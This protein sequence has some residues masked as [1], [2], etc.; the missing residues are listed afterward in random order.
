MHLP[1]LAEHEI[2][3]TLVALALHIKESLL[4]A[5]CFGKGTGFGVGLILLAPIFRLILG[6]GD[7]KY[8]GKR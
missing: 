8:I 7:A 5:R 3:M 6:F 4:L 2:I 1:T